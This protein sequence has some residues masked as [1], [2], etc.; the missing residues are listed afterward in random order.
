[1]I[2]INLKRKEGNNDVTFGIL[3]I[4]AYG[5]KCHTM[6]LKDS[7]D[8]VYKQNCRVPEGAYVLEHSCHEGSPFFPQF[9]KKPKG[10]SVKPRFE[11]QNL[12]Y[13]NLPSGMIAIGKRIGTDPATFSLEQ[14]EAL[15]KTFI[16]LF[17]KIFHSTELV[18][19]SIY[20]GKYYQHHDISYHTIVNAIKNNA[21]MND[22]E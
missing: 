11:L 21:W 1:M 13:N 22:D 3:E 5:F 8:L 9:K 12:R 16:E 2:Q 20:K 19:L 15:N 14:S 6:E 17:E 4:P 10:F 7:A 18:V